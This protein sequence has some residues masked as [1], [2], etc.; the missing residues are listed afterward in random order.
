[1]LVMSELDRVFYLGRAYVG[2]A[3]DELFGTGSPEG[4]AVSELN[5]AL[6]EGVPMKKTEQQEFKTHVAAMSD[7]E[8]EIILGVPTEAPFN[9]LKSQ[10]ELLLR[11]LAEFEKKQPEKKSIAAREK[12]RIEKAFAVLS[13]KVDSTE[14]RF[15]SLEIE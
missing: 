7:E 10:Y 15:G 8:A 4:K 12:Q 6:E 5:Q 14:K 13:A 11:H 2:K 9:Q 1:M 3:Q